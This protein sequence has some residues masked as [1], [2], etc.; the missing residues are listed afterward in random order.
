[1]HFIQGGAMSTTIGTQKNALA[2]MQ[3][4]FVRLAFVFVLLP[5]ICIGGCADQKQ[6]AEG[7]VRVALEHSEANRNAE[8]V[9]V[10]NRAVALNPGLAE[11]FYLRG[12]CNAKLYRKDQAL[13]DL[14]VATRLK[15]GW[16]EAWC[17]LG[18]AQINAGDTASGVDSLTRAVE[19][20]PR[21]KASR[22]ARVKLYRELGRTTEELADLN[23]LLLTDSENTDALLRRAEL[24]TES[25]PDKAT[26]DLSKVIQLE[27]DNGAAWLQRGLC[28]S[29]TGD[30][31]RGLA[32][33]NIACRLLSN[34]YRPW[35]ERGRI[36]RELHRSEDAV[37]DLSQAAR[38]APNQSE[39]S[40]ELG[41]AFLDAAN[42]DAAEANVL[43]AEKLSPDNG[44]VQ[45]ALKQIESARGHRT[46]D[47][48]AFRNLLGDADTNSPEDVAA[49]RARLEKQ[50]HVPDQSAKTP[51]QAGQPQNVAASDSDIRP[52]QVDLHAKSDQYEKAT[53]DSTRLVS[54]DSSPKDLTLNRG[55]LRLQ[56]QEWEA[57]AADFTAYLAVHPNDIEAISLRAQCLIKQNQP[58]GAISDLS[59]AI[60]R[61]PDA[62]DLYLMRADAF[63]Q[64]NEPEAA[65]ADLQKAARLQPE[66]FA[67]LESTAARL[68]QRRQFA[69]AA[70]LLDSI[71]AARLAEVP[72]SLRLLRGKV[73]LADN[74]L[75]GADEDA[76]ALLDSG[77][78][79]AG[80]IPAKDIQLLQAMIALR[81]QHDAESIQLMQN[82]ELDSVSAEY[83]LLYGHALARQGQSDAAIRIFTLVLDSDRSNTSALVSR[84]AVRMD[85]SDWQGAIDDADIV[86]HRVP[87]D[88]KAVLI[89]GTCLFQNDRFR[90][91]LDVLDKLAVTQQDTSE[92]RWM[93][94]QCC[95][96]L[97]LTFREMEELNALLG[98]SPTHVEAR[99]LRAKSLEMLGRFDDAITDLSAALEQDSL[100]LATLTRRGIL[101]QRQGNAAAS[102]EDF[103]AAITLYADDAELWYRRGISQSQLGSLD[104]AT[105]DFDKAI[106]LDPD[107]AD[108]WYAIGN[109]EAG[110][111][112]AD[113]A[114]AAYT[115]AVE[116]QPEHAAAWYNR[117]NL[118]FDQAKLQRAVDCWSI[119][120]QIQPDMFP[121]Y[122]NRAAAYDRIGQDSE[123]VADY[124]KALELNPRFVRA[125]DN[126]AWLLATSEYKKV[127]DPARAVKAATK[128]CELS[129]FEDWT[130]LNTLATCSAEHR[131]LEAAVK[132]ARKAREFAPEQEH[133]QLDQI[134]HTY[135][136]QLKTKRV[137]TSPGGSRR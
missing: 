18:I 27:R 124:E 50:L 29:R 42:I 19:I 35:L 116:L 122:N 53:E 44:N 30:T 21:S 77:E 36:L 9:Q 106:Q 46:V 101:N 31:D 84:A 57:A 54:T 74:D 58:A 71:E 76:R 59:M 96:K 14:T 67:L 10:L 86:L 129:K 56:S 100:N 118:L 38:L 66:N 115:K 131:D 126:L 43:R 81:R 28:Y 40:L 133:A 63:D 4:S 64:F 69:D 22:E 11:A 117:G 130:C 135:E 52:T 113:E 47:V 109:V 103:S 32:D 15:P 68:I 5:M 75:N 112:H 73:R 121:A 49:T 105:Q 37:S 60:T 39:C 89:K 8:A 83:L 33:L 13:V 98:V 82:I 99:L 137:T 61:H 45:L 79:S 92:T 108:T 3:D 94:I 78:K 90:E 134:V 119:A 110:R 26:N 51:P 125:W 62:A 132:W 136:T 24:L 114:L 123:A 2:S 97:Q 95:S 70:R 128:A 20:N 17:S 25:D 55:R 104:A 93:R 111:G 91:A 1:M 80:S 102:I 127:R 85:A 72:G 6:Q 65:L 34:D 48:G 7:L 107:S 87:D 120:I 16:D 12:T 41:L 88:P 23:E